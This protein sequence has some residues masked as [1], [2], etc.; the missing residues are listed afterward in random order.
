MSDGGEEVAESGA[1]LAQFLEMDGG[2]ALDHLLAVA[3]EMQFDP[4]AVR[5]GRRASE[6]PAAHQAINQADR[7]MVADLQAISEFGDK[8]VVAPGKTLQDEEGLMLLHGQSG[9]AGGLLAEVQEYAQR[10]PDGGE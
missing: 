9:P 7:A 8:G 10:V 3:G 2:Q 6:Q 4:T 1:E 5:R